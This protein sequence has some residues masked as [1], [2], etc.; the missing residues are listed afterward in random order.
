MD[1]GLRL[2]IQISDTLTFGPELEV[3]KRLST[4]AFV[5]GRKARTTIFVR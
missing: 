5:A 2:T 3:A 1:T 4:A